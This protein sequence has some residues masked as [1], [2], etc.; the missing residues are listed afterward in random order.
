ML[1]DNEVKDSNSVK[2][3]EIKEITIKEE[4]HTSAP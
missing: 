3:G 4:K 2:D 1:D